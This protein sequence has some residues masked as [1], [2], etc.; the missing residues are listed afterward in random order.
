M[1]TDASAYM[2]LAW[3]DITLKCPTNHVAAAYANHAAFLQGLEVG[4]RL[5]KEPNK[6]ATY[7]DRLSPHAKN[8]F[9]LFALHP[10]QRYEAEWLATYLKIP[11]GR[12]GV[13]GVWAWPG[14]HAKEL[15]MDYPWAWHS[16]GIDT[17]YWLETEEAELYA[18][19]AAE[20]AAQA[21]PWLREVFGA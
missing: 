2:T 19:M 17:F 6:A 11:H 8:L 18:P 7:W 12:S 1:T 16:D 21:E 13:A 15:G 3:T 14:R 10:K 4:L 9:T 5:S 20:W